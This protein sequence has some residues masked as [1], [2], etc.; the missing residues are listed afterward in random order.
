M[1]AE[2]SGPRG[3]GGAIPLGP[4]T[5]ARPP[6][7]QP[8]PAPRPAPVPE[9]VTELDE[10]VALRPA[11]V[12]PHQRLPAKFAMLSVHR[13]YDGGREAFRLRGHSGGELETVL[14]SEHTQLRPKNLALHNLRQGTGRPSLPSELLMGLEE[15]SRGQ[16][17]LV[18]WINA[19]RARHGAELQLVIWDDTD[20]DI[21]WEL[22][23]LSGGQELGMARE[24]LGAL[25]TVVRWTT[26]HGAG[27]SPFGEP[28]ACSGHVLGFYAEQMRQ[29]AEVFEEYQHSPHFVRPWPFLAELTR[30]ELGAGL[31]Y[32]GCH[33][34]YGPDAHDVK[35]DVVS[36]S[37]LNLQP[38]PALADGRT[39]VCLNACDSARAFDN[40]GRGEN[41]LRGFAELFL[42]KGAGGCIATSGKVGDKTAHQ[43][44]RELVKRVCA[45]PELPVA[46]ALR[47]FRAGAAARLPVPLWWLD[48]ED[49]SELDTEREILESLYSF[50]FVYFGHPF[51]TLR[52][53]G[54]TEE[55]GW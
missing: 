55:V 14:D 24:I 52:L 8:L 35:I 26:V 50:M 40:Q 28:A 53:R 38:M 45:D 25:V 31:V 18:R 43:Q 3:L 7:P 21:P 4:G 10:A 9:H 34:E 5:P 33:A 44:I 11:A 2:P 32:M 49:R 47:E 22:L 30:R 39:L 23:H 17:A 41:A 15:W 37:R 1:S 27:T 29:D 48:G 36:W 12:D 13:A 51:T 42:R 54:R 16:E 20:Y 6:A 46:R 19:L